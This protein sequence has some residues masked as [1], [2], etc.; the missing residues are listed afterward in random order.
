MESTTR[1]NSSKTSKRKERISPVETSENKKGRHAC[2]S[3]QITAPPEASGLSA[4]GRQY[5]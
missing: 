4:S 3:Y 2:A 5:V 1:M